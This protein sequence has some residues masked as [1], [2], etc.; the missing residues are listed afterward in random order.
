[1]IVLHEAYDASGPVGRIYVGGNGT[2][3]Q[4]HNAV[5]TFDTFYTMAFGYKTDDCASSLNGDSP[6]TD[7]SV[8]LPDKANITM[9]KI[10]RGYQDNTNVGRLK[11]LRYY[12]KK[13]SNAA[14]QLLS[15]N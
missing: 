6:N 9:M 7:S 8:V 4:S 2:F 10:M 1:M 3:G 12:P 14:I 13:L 11:Y 5:T 15:T